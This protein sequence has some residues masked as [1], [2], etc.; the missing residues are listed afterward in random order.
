MKRISLFIKSAVLTAVIIP[1]LYVFSLGGYER[2]E[3]WLS[4]V[5]FAKEYRAAHIVEPKVI[6][7]S[8]SNSLF[9]F[10]SKTLE[11]LIGKPVV[12]LAGHAALS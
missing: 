4:D 6:I 5:Y 1:L 10:D 11:N 8:G 3:H 9:G 12:N 2:A 7:V